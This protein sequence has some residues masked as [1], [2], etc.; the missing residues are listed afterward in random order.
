MRYSLIDFSH[1]LH[2]LLVQETAGMTGP[3]Y[4]RPPYPSTWARA[5]GK[6]RV[7]YSSMGHLENT[8][9]SPTFQDILFGGISWATGVVD[10]D[11]TP[12]IE[13]V[14]PDCWTVP[15]VSNPVASDP[16]KYNPKKELWVQ[17][18]ATQP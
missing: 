7:F 10:A 11:I 2:V 9:T 5:Y 17:A 8:W 13:Q 18:P 1:D 14:A 16:A 12:N 4:Q 3:P 6:G 15:P